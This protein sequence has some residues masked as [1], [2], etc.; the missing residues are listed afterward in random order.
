MEVGALYG[1]LI[2][3]WLGVVVARQADLSG[4]LGA[5]GRYASTAGRSSMP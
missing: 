2:C 1:H 5:T 4:W 3:S